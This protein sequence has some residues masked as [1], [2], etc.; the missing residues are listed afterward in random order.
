M[1]DGPLST[2][3]VLPSSQA[4]PFSW[5]VAADWW[6]VVAQDWHLHGNV[7]PWRR[8]SIMSWYC[9]YDMPVPH[10]R[11]TH[12]RQSS[13]SSACWR[14]VTTSVLWQSV[15]YSSN[16]G[17]I[18]NYSAT[19][20]LKCDWCSLIARRWNCSAWLTRVVSIVCA[21]HFLFFRTRALT[22]GNNS[23][24]VLTSVYVVYS[25]SP[26]INS[27]EQRYRPSTHSLWLW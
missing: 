19:P 21:V 3:S 10:S 7:P 15:L 17:N 26:D 27:D 20:H 22:S 25:L 13:H 18:A 1:V 2:W 24:A 6:V 5:N 12:R 16:P 4:S 23:A 8:F 9:V 14:A 11:W